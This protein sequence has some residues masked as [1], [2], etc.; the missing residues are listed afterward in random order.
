MKV[1]RCMFVGVDEPV[2]Y[3]VRSYT[4][5]PD[6][7]RVGVPLGPAIV[8]DAVPGPV[9]DTVTTPCVAPVRTLK[10]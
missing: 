9:H 7:D 1:T 3:V 8:T 5:A 2:W 10:L 6:S 4:T